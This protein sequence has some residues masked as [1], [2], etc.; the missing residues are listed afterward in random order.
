MEPQ[1]RQGIAAEHLVPL[2]GRLL[3]LYFNIVKKELLTGRK[4]YLIINSLKVGYQ[5]G[6][7]FTTRF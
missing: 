2:H 5:G 4:R 7:I 3:I 1:V 6:A